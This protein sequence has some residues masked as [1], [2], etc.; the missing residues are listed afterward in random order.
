MHLLDQNVFGTSTVGVLT[1][2][3]TLNGKKIQKNGRTDIND[4]W[5]EARWLFHNFGTGGGSEG[6][7]G[8]LSDATNPNRKDGA[9]QE[10]DWKR[11]SVQGSG[12]YYTQKLFNYLKTNYNV[13]C[14]YEITMH[15]IGKVKP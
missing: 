8:I 6:C 2:A 11:T 1:D 3:T 7:Y 9:W 15:N 13:Y 12:A 5:K 14:R 10:G 4:T